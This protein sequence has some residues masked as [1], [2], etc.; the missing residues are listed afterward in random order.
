M[1]FEGLD[2]SLF[3]G[4]LHLPLMIAGFV[5]AGAIAFV[6]LLATP[7]SKRTLI[8]ASTMVMA[9]LSLGARM[10]PWTCIRLGIGAQT[11]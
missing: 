7:V 8:L 9:M 11:R 4:W 5:A 6:T 1:T 10:P 3:P 2:A